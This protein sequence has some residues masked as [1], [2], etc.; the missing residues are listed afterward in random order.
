M[1]I[2]KVFDKS[3]GR[4][5]VRRTHRQLVAMGYSINHKKV[6]RLMHL[7]GLKGRSPKE[8][9]H[10]YEGKVGK[11][12]SNIIDRDF[13]TNECNQKWS[14]DISQF[15]LP[16]GKVYFSPILDMCNNEIVAYNLSQSPN[17][18]QI[19]DMLDKV[20]LAR[21]DTEGLIIH[22]DQ[23]WQYQH[24]FY[25]EEL[26]KHGIVQSMSRKG[27][28]YDNC[29]IES[30]F[31]RLK[32][33]MFYGNEKSYTSFEEFAKAIHEYIDWYNNDRIQAKTKWMS[34][35]EFRMTSTNAV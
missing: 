24:Q 34:P 3:K 10:S 4:Y 30:F 14:T 35:V 29:I 21:T 17:L 32:C 11:V 22:S 2:Q 18:E 5:G 15:T 8:K 12:A 7:M 19:K 23:G 27:N 25:T 13:H 26:K 31:G 9:Y 16:F 28:C 33:E 1:E 20:F 6:Q